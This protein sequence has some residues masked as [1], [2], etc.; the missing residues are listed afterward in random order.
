MDQWKRFIDWC[1]QPSKIKINDFNPRN[2]TV[3]ITLSIILASSITFG[4]WNLN[5]STQTIPPTLPPEL[6][7]VDS[8]YNP[9][10]SV[11][12]YVAYGNFVCNQEHPEGTTCI[13]DL[14]FKKAEVVAVS[15]KD[16]T[17]L[18][19]EQLK[20][21]SATWRDGRTEIWDVEKA[22]W[23][24]DTPDY[25]DSSLIIAANLTVGDCIQLPTTPISD[26]YVAETD[27]R[28]YLDVSRNVSILRM[29]DVDINGETRGT[30]NFV[31]DQ[32]SG[33]RLEYALVTLDGKVLSSMSVVE[34]NVFSTS[35]P[36]LSPVQ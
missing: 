30:F 2:F 31:Y 17:F 19:S 27:V 11:G 33:V 12:D 28:T 35:P 13:G 7:T 5:A 21:G 9:G 23:S 15:G 3:L 29:R 24:D 8:G 32:E 26:F 18:H 25:V 36:P 16:V 20:N 14:A 4:A 34:T 1:Q 22:V 6:P 10:V